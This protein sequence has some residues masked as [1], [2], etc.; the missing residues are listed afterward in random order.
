MSEVLVIPGTAARHRVAGLTVVERQVLVLARAGARR[1]VVATADDTVRGLVAAVAPRAGGT[2]IDVV[3]RTPSPPPPLVV[4]EDVV[5][6][7]AFARRALASGGPLRA[8][9]ASGSVFLPVTTAGERRAAERALLR[10][11]IKPSDGPVSRHFNRRM[12]LAVTRL[13]L[14][15]AVTPNQ[16]TI[17]A[18]AIGALGVALVFHGGWGWVVAGAALVQGQS[19]LD[20][21]DG[22]IAR[23][24][25]LSSRFGEWLDNVLDDVI[26]AAYALAL[27][28]AATAATG[29]P[30]WRWLSLGSL[31]AITSYSLLQYHQLVFIHRSGNPFLFRWWFQRDGA[32]L[33]TTFARPT[34]GMRTAAF[35]RSLSRRDVFLLAFLGLALADIPAAAVVWYALVAAGHLGMTIAHVANGG[36]PKATA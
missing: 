12:S 18:N 16:M 3:E 4:D 17:L 15:T 6:D 20:G 8:V 21:S 13:L 22:E 33:T 19:I 9:D 7:L 27:G 1:I 11:L 2:E 14:D 31:A 10:S 23:L 28:F 34:P 29:N 25:F 32:D 24:K 35:F 36:L 26:N 30:V 5:F